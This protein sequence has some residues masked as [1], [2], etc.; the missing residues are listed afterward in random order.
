M[1]DLTTLKSEL[2]RHPKIKSWT[3]TQ[4][5]IHRRERY[6]MTDGGQSLVTDQDRNVFQ[7]NI[8]VKL[9]VHLENKPDRQGEIT[10]KF[11]P[12]LALAPQL[13]SAVDAALQ[14]DHK[15]WDLPAE[16][17]SQIPTLQTTDP[18]MAEDLDGVVDEVSKTISGLVSKKRDTTFNS[19][20]LF[21]S[22][23]N[24]E[25]YLSNGLSHRASQSRIY[26]EAAYSYA[27]KNKSGESESDEYL[28]TR[29][30]VNLNDL[31]LAEVFDETSDRAQHSL[32]LEKPLTGKY[33]VIIDAEVL[34]TLFSTYVS[35]LSASNAY[36]ELPFI[37]IGDEFIPEATG[38]LLT[39]TLDPS[40]AHGA[41]TTALSE[42][43]VLQKPLKLVENNRVLASLMD[44]QYAD[45]MKQAPTSSRGNIVV[46]PGKLNYS[47]LT[48]S[49]PQVLEILQFS[50]LFAD[51][52][53]GT[54]SSEIRLARLYDNVKGTVSYLKGGS[55]SG[56]IRD[57]FKN[58]KLCSKQVK[59][60]HFES[61]SMNG[62]GYYGPEYA[63]L[64]DVSIV[65]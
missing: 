57:N 1:W 3:I 6:F 27:R 28:N 52:F 24:R 63:V 42:Q 31:P 58:A 20:E 40:L 8:Q 4:E 14:T 36:N 2:K 62:Q 33:P 21:M 64:S 18:K 48:K 22:V 23:H 11:F 29:W 17:P 65:G 30:A 37:K 61:N 13:E 26:V 53:S 25:F 56:S 60:A 43:G 5:N 45:Y 47:E 50:G 10:K 15:S 7:Q 54:F 19:A 44:K 16:I 55:L 39:V 59:R 49:A 46:A 12:S 51:P 32:G 35:Q 34:A 41:D 38:D 9:A